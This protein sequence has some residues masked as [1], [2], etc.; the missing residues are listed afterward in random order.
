MCPTRSRAVTRRWAEPDEVILAVEV[1]RTSIRTDLGP[2]ARQYAGW[3]AAEY[4]V[5]DLNERVVVVHTDPGD[6]GYRSVTRRTGRDAVGFRCSD[7]VMAAEDLL[8]VPSA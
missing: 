1:A 5:L 2:K 8:T 7:R 3:G 4:W 6:D